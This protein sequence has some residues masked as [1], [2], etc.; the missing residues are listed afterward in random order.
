MA[1]LMFCIE[2]SSPQARTPSPVRHPPL[3]A[4]FAELKTGRAHVIPTSKGR[5]KQFADD[6]IAIAHSPVDTRDTHDPQS[7]LPPPLDVIP[8][9]CLE[10]RA[11]Q[12]W[13]SGP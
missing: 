5:R 3:G 7:T 4:S 2:L 8:I 13:S 1:A 6:S 10:V 12:E 11:S 9:S